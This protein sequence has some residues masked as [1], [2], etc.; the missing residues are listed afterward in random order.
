MSRT[1][2]IDLIQAISQ[3]QSPLPPKAAMHLVRQA[4]CAAAL[5]GGTAVSL[6][7]I[8]I[9]ASGCVSL[10]PPLP[11]QNAV[12]EAHTVTLRTMAILF[13]GLTL[14]EVFLVED[15]PRFLR[16]LLRSALP[17]LDAETDALLGRLLGL[18]SPFETPV[19]ALSE[20]AGMRPTMGVRSYGQFCRVLQPPQAASSFRSGLVEADF[21]QVPRSW[22]SG[23]AVGLVLGGLATGLIAASFVAGFMARGQQPG[24]ALGEV[25]F[26]K[27][28]ALL[29]RLAIMETQQARRPAVQISQKPVLT[30]PQ[31]VERPVADCEP[32]QVVDS[33]LHGK[34]EVQGRVQDRDFVARVRVN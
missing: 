14:G 23:L 12:L 24:E 22:R 21:H 26:Q 27:L 19:E 33:V 15:D 31:R 32:I 5:A 4:L 25:R 7:R 6:D 13:A 1:T 2:A 18:E 28:E 34:P 16:S 17:D 3:G 29:Q 20:I 8:L 9:H 11:G 30:A 10:V